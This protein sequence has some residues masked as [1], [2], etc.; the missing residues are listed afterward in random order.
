MKKGLAYVSLFMSVLMF[1]IFWNRPNWATALTVFPSW[2][3]LTFWLFALPAKKQKVFI[4]ATVGWVLFGLFQVEE[5]QSML[6]SL[7]PVEVVED[8]L[9]ISTINCSG[10][11][12]ALL[13]A[14]AEEPDVILVK[15]SPSREFIEGLINEKEG[16]AYLYGFDTS[17]IVR[18]EISGLKNERI[19]IAGDAIIDTK[20]YIIVSLRLLTSNPR[21]DLYR[22]DCWQSQT[23]MRKRQTEQLTEIVNLLPQDVACIV[24]G[25][26][27][28]PQRDKV[29]SYMREGMVDSFSSGGRGWC[30]T[31]LV[32]VPLLRIDQIWTSSELSCFD[33]YARESE[34]TDHRLYTASMKK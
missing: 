13:D 3:W 25:D 19:Y 15:E 1:F 2:I 12:K 22:L 7:R 10:S 27:N 17:I 6:R 20:R 34:G 23:F 4:F 14:F 5:W 31:I 11:N 16:Y 21:V 26:F 30:N 9:R 8:D 18:G 33:A 29:F 24:G 28:V 32:D